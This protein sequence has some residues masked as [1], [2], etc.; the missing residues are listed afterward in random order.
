MIEI[1][2]QVV[3]VLEPD[4]DSNHAVADAKVMKALMTYAQGTGAL[5]AH[6]VPEPSLSAGTC[7]TSGE[8]SSRRGLPSVPAMAERMML[9]RDLALVESTGARYHADQVTTAA[10]LPALARARDAGLD[11]SA[12]ISIHHLTLNGQ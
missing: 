5:I 4:G 7:A 1:L 9:E 2:F 10:A 12:G 8:F 3:D 6:H 11:V